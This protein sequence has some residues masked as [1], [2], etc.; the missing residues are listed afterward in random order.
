M[1]GSSQLKIQHEQWLPLT[2]GLL[3]QGCF[4]LDPGQNGVWHDPDRCKEHRLERCFLD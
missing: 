4:W 2:F 3:V 1:R